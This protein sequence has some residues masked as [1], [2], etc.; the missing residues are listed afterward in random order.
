MEDGWMEIVNLEKLVNFSRKVI[1]YNFDE[2]NS[3]LKD[4]DFLEKIEKIENTDNAEMDTVLPY[5]ECR[6]M[7][8]SM[9]K[10]QK[11]KKLLKEEDY[12]EF[13]S[14]LNERMISNIVQGLV[15]KGVLESAFDDE[16]NDFVFWIKN[17][18]DYEKPE[19]D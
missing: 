16:K 11:T 7:L 13:L 12:D 17:S 5:S 10:T 3:E 4:E 15:N 1:F 19:T 8:Q 14:Q 18:E 6:L 9:I 2:E